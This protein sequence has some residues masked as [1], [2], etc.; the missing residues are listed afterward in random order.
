[1]GE[2]AP[3]KAIAYG[4]VSGPPQESVRSARFGAASPRARLPRL[5]PPWA[6]RACIAAEQDRTRL[7]EEGSLERSV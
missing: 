4:T 5:Q 6:P 1:M 2:A 7:P 3:P